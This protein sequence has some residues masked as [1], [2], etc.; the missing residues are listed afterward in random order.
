MGNTPEG[1]RLLDMVKRQK[2]EATNDAIPKG[3]KYIAPVEA[4][5]YYNLYTTFSNAIIN[6]NRDIGAISA[7]QANQHRH[8]LQD[9][10]ENRRSTRRSERQDA[11]D[12][13]AAERD[14]AEDEY[15]RWLE[16]LQ[17]GSREFA[18]VFDGIGLR[19]NANAGVYNGTGEGVGTGLPYVNRSTALKAI[20]KLEDLS[21]KDNGLTDA[22]KRVLDILN[23]REHPPKGVAFGNWAQDRIDRILQEK[24]G[25]NRWGVSN[26]LD[27]NKTIVQLAEENM[28]ALE[29]KGEKNTPE[30]RKWEKYYTMGQ[31]SIDLAR[32]RRNLRKERELL[33]EYLA[34]NSGT[35]IGS[36]G[37]NLETVDD[38]LEDY[39]SMMDEVYDRLSD[40]KPLDEDTI[41]D[42]D[43]YEGNKRNLRG[44]KKFIDYLIREAKKA[45]K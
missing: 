19:L 21:R 23:A 32:G 34:N 38:I 24:T 29:N 39:E 25:A 8:N 1:K 13:R 3:K 40:P 42:Q 33:D 37:E 31:M 28:Y 17:G 26:N 9:L 11:I 15:N 44:M 4:Q 6:V 45:K 22:Q 27:Y 5:M 20:K 36:N 16:T 10:G 7:R 12:A 18:E 43:W 14:A 30:Y 35:I 2:M 41:D